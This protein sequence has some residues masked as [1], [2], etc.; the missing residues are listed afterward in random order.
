MLVTAWE[1]Y[2]DLDNHFGQIIFS[3]RDGTSNKQWATPNLPAVEYAAAL[4]TVSSGKT[5][6]LENGYRL[7]AR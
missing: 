3:Y 1:A 2:W 5:V 7:V 6:F 4:A